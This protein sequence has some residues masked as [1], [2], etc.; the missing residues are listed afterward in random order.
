M[1]YEQREDRKGRFGDCLKDKMAGSC[2]QVLVWAH[3]H[4]FLNVSPRHSSR[5]RRSF[6]A[7]SWV[8][9]NDES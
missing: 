2:G 9:L 8:F 5:A 4:N 1:Q 6:S 3:G 7:V